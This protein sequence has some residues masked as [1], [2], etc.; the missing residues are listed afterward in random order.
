MGSREEV[1]DLERSLG[2]RITSTLFPSAT[3]HRAPPAPKFHPLLALGKRVEPSIRIDQSRTVKLFRRYQWIEPLM[4]LDVRA[5]LRRLQSMFQ[6]DPQTV[7]AAAADQSRGSTI[8]V[9]VAG[10][11]KQ[12][13]P[14]V[15]GTFRAACDSG[16]ATSRSGRS[17]G[18]GTVPILRIRRFHAQQLCRI[19]E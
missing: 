18:D 3:K 19:V 12:S 6:V 9:S 2:S 5:R 17:V 16:A 10:S 14:G 4:F 15:E 1:V 8:K 11:G 13:S 7:L